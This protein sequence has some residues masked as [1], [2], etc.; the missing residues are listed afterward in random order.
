MNK[1]ARYC[2]TH[3]A[4]LIKAEIA[5]DGSKS[6][7]NRLLLI[8]ALSPI[9]FPI[10]RLSSSDDTQTMVAA[11]AQPLNLGK[12]TVDVG[13]AGT[14]MRFLTAYFASREGSEV[15]LTGSAR[16]QERPIAILVDALRQ[17]GADI[18]YVKASGYPPLHISG[19]RLSGGEISLPAHISSQYLSA[20]LMIAPIL[21]NGLTLQLEGEIV[22]RSYILLTLSLLSQLGIRHY[23][24][25][26]TITI[27]PSQPYQACPI[28]VEA[29]W[30]SASYYYAAAALAPSGADITLRGLA[31]QSAQGDSIL[32]QL[33]RQLGV[34]TTFLPDGIRLQSQ[35]HPFSPTPTPLFFNCTNCPDIAQTLIVVC[36]ALH[37]PAIFSGL[38]TL[39][40]KE[41]DRIA[42]LHQELSKFGAALLPL[43]DALWIVQPMPH[44]MPPSEIPISIATY[45]DHRMAMS[46]APLALKIP[47]CIENPMVVS[48]SYPNFWQ[49]WEKLGFHLQ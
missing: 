38:S 40:I 5:L 36:A 30:S 6:I 22:S 2:L 33:M 13:A 28:T 35:L 26:N 24:S 43:P 44:P 19:K 9:P 42:A 31:D 4:K 16:M 29:D 46:F 47:I 8:K 21:D 27:P 23:W 14:A 37:Q 10:S 15:I 18:Q 39:H 12:M 41:T 7:S 25:G 34:N 20:L 49:D 3:T 1:Q 17:L 48:K 11:L 45:D 32:P